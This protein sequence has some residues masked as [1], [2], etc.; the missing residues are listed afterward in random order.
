MRYKK[1]TELMADEKSKRQVKDI[2]PSKETQFFAMYVAHVVRNAMEDFHCKYLG[3]EQMKELNPIIR[4]AI[5]SALHASENHDEYENARLFLEF[6][7]RTIPNY[8]E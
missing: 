4:N 8:G 5:C 2:K 1:E 6:H 3:D 7:L